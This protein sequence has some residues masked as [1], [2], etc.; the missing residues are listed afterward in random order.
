MA[1]RCSLYVRVDSIL[2]FVYAKNGE[3]HKDQFFAPFL[4]N[5][6]KEIYNNYCLNS[7]GKSRDE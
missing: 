4:G 2:A 1:E 7:T 5:P 3:R 6:K